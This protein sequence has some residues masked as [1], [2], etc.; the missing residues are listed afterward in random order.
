MRERG[1][2]HQTR[3][4]HKVRHTDLRVDGKTLRHSFLLRDENGDSR[5]T[6]PDHLAMR[7]KPTVQGRQCNHLQML[8]PDPS[9]AKDDWL[10]VGDCTYQCVG[11]WVVQGVKQ[12]SLVRCYRSRIESLAARSGCVC[13]HQPC[14][15]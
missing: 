8:L 11:P 12:V 9:I 4:L 3:R 1:V 13:R 14:H 15:L 2:L 10:P 7:S 6:R 5:A